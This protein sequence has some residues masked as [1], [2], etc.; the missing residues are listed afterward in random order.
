MIRNLKKFIP[1]VA[2]IIIFS[3]ISLAYFSPVLQGKKLF[4]SDIQQFTG[5]AKA[6]NDF[7]AE[8]HQEPYWT[9]TA[10]SG[11][12]TYNLSALYP[13]DFVKYIDRAV[14]FLPRPANY[15]FLYFFSFF[16]LLLVL[17]VEKKIALL[18]A[19]G[20]GF[21][22]YLIIILG[23]GHNAKA[24]A[25]GYM[26]LV[27]A[28]ILLLFKNKQILGF[29]LT[30]LAFSLELNAS[31]PQM[32]YYLG[33]AVF[34]FG[35]IYLID[36]F[37]RNELIHF[38]KSTILIVSA[39]ILA[40]GMNAT[41]LMATKEFAQHS[42]RGPSEL[43]INADGSAKKSSNGLT[44]S[45][46]TEYSYGI[47]ETFN[48]F[49]PRF[50]G[51]GNAENVGYNSNTYQ[52]L[53]NKINPTQARQ[54]ATQAPMYWGKQP[55]VEAPAY[56]GAVFIFLFVLGLFLLKGKI[57]NWLIGVIVF[58]I[59]MS[60]GKNFSFLTDF[61]IQY[62]P[63][64]NKF[65]AVSSIQ[66]L[67]ELAVPLFGIIALHNF[68]NK[69]N[70]EEVKIKALKKSFFITGGLAL[71]FVLLGKSFFAFE[72]VHDSAYGKMIPGFL[73]AIIADRK[74]LFFNDSLRTLILVLISAGVLWFVVKQ[75]LKENYALIVLGILIV[76][77]LVKIDKNYVNNTSFKQAV[78]I[79]KPFSKSLI[80]NEILKDTSY[81]RVANYERSLMND[82][83]TSY[84]HKSI[85]GY[86]AAK[87]RRYQDLY[88]FQIAK[89][90]VEVLNMLNTKYFIFTDN[91]NRLAYQP[92]NEAN[93]N[94]WFI[95]K[96]FKVNTA[97]DEIK[98]LDTLQ[99]KKHAVIRKS[100]AKN[101]S[102]SYEKDSLATIQLVA[103]QLNKLT[104]QSNATRNQFAVFSEIYYQPGWQA[105]IDGKKENHY[106]VD[107]VLRGMPIPKGKHQIEFKF[108]PQVIK[109][110]NTITL[111][112]YFIF[113]IIFVFGL[114]YQLKFLRKRK[115]H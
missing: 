17:N 52:F 25:I 97:N 30:T 67:A 68:L 72:G 47:A 24:H 32:T 61:F 104:Y 7:R 36:A 31:H 8:Q 107:Y 90:N 4:Q 22:T 62:V 45:Y 84:F 46:I 81:Y 20:F 60:W 13:N 83:A 50:M 27:L 69:E 3:I 12:P 57:K 39:L 112:S 88:D 48:L 2:V 56:I 6:I 44:K 37:K 79:E 74:D 70:S 5:M 102:N 35:L 15:L 49:I 71:F 115:A 113:L 33:F 89:N 73:E 18:G 80:D 34:I 29:L 96:L 64:Y 92:N 43:T 54:F 58:S 76:F 87:L 91:N 93:G 111:T 105:Y 99:T 82:G 85:G 100:L 75:K 14:L 19:I 101:L 110:G 26:P 53:K 103:H 108:E 109:R 1:Y 65:R 66:V 55:I 41:R 16:I 63:Y 98:A 11:M 9:D 78:T 23:V 94:V 40:F 114:G 106:Q 86:F 42:T 10:F 21:S 59:L 95:N 28:G 51:G 38:F 77:D